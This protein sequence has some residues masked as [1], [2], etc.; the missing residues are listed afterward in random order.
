[1]AWHHYTCRLTDR[2]AQVLIRDDFVVSPPID[3]CPH[4]VW[5]GIW[6]H[7][8]PEGAFWHPDESA[9]LDDLEDELL[10]AVQQGT[11]GTALY[12]FRLAA[13]GIREYFVYCSDPSQI[14]AAGHSWAAT[15]PDYRIEFAQLSDPSWHEYRKYAALASPSGP[16]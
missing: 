6:G 4:L 16:A 13:A 1:M 12:A 8:A 5:A 9:D 2:T 7:L 14:I 10:A 3:R 15:H 11:S